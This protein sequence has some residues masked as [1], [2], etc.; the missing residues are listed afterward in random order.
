[1][2]SRLSFPDGAD[3]TLDGRESS[4]GMAGDVVIDGSEAVLGALQR[5]GR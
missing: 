2:P 4:A 5:S 3:G 1:M